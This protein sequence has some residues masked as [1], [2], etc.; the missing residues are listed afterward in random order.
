[1]ILT[2]LTAAISI[3]ILSIATACNDTNYYDDL[4]QEIAEFISQYY[5]NTGVESYSDTDNK[6]VL[7]LKDGPG[8]TFNSSYNWTNINGYGSVLP[9]VLLFDQTPPALY[10]YLQATDCLDGVYDMSRDTANYYLTLLSSSIT[11]NISSEQ[12]TGHDTSPT[13]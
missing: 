4:P 5:P 9:Q 3:A 11:Y 10:Q 12:I 7:K 13:D 1:M 2:R 6:Y 8:M